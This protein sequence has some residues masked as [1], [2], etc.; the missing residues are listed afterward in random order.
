MGIALLFGF[1]G[2]KILLF[3]V[4]VNT[5]TQIILNVLLNVINFNS[6]QAAFVRGYV[7]L[8]I[9]IFAIEAVIYS[10]IMRKLNDYKKSRSFYV[11]YALAANAV[12]FG[13][14]MVIA[15]ILPGIF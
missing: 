7:M 5:A 3:L 12:S 13:A 15:H 1:R 11:I 6:G 10:T 4:A 2:K 14:G 9:L 8:E